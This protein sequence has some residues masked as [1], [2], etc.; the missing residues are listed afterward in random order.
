MLHRDLAA[1]LVADEVEVARQR[2][3]ARVTCL[4]ARGAEVL[5]TFPG[6]A[7]KPVLLRLDGRAYDAEPFR[8]AVVDE[9]GKILPARAWP[10]GLCLGR[11]PY[12]QV[13]FACVQGAYEYHAHPSHAA[14]S[15]DRHRRR[16]RLAELLDHLLR[17]AGR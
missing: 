17:K 10:P 7:G 6:R 9:R 15:W 8:V 2:L 11:H 5:C 16:I 12:L 3:G 1:E 14:E 4:Q 13:P